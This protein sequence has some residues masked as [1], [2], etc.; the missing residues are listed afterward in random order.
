MVFFLHSTRFTIA[1]DSLPMFVVNAP[2]RVLN[3]SQS[4]DLNI[5]NQ[6]HTR[7]VYLSQRYEDLSNVG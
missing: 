6:T 2:P 4:H 7:M 3:S 5:Y 1:G